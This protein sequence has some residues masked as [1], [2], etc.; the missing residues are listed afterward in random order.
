M[1]DIFRKAIVILI[2]SM[3]LLNSSL[4]LIISSAV[5][6]IEE[7]IDESKVNVLYNINLE[8]YVNYAIEDDK[9]TLVQI[10]LKTGVEFVEGQKYYPI[11]KTDIALNLPKIEGEYPNKVEVIGISTKATNGNEDAKDIKNVYN[12][13]TGEIRIETTNGSNEEGNIYSE[14]VNG[15][16]DEYKLILYYSTQVFSARNIAR[17]LEIKGKIQESF[18]RGKSK[19]VEINEIYNVT[20]NIS[21]LISTDVNTSDIYNGGIK[22]NKENGTSQKTE[23]IENITINPSYRN[24]SD[25]VQINLKNAFI[26]ENNIETEASEI[27]YKSTK[28]NKNEVLEQLGKEGYLQILNE[29]GDI[30][31]EI[32]KDTESG[33]NG[34]VE[35]NYENEISNIIIKTSKIEEL[36]GITIQNVREIKETVKDT[37]IHKI[38]TKGEISCINGGKEVYHFNSSSTTQIK[39]SETRIDVSVD[40]QQLTNNIQNDVV[41]TADLITNKIQYNLFKNPVLEIK[42]PTEVE[43]VILGEVSLLYDENLR[44]SSAEVIDRDNSKVIRMQIEGIQK[45]Y[46]LNS[47]ITGA[48]I[49]IPATIVVKKDIESVDSNIDVTYYNESG[50]NNDYTNR[51]L[52]S[53]IIPISII[54]AFELKE[55]ITTFT[56]NVSTTGD[57][58]ELQLVAYA[59]VGNQVLKD[60]DKVK[61]HEIIRYVMQIKNNSNNDISGLKI[62]AQVP[63]GT[64]YVSIDKSAYLG[65]KYEY[66]EDDTKRTIEED[67]IVIKSGEVI[68]KYYEV[69]A[70]PLGADQLQQ[71]INNNIQLLLNQQQYATL[72]LGNVIEKASIKTELKS[73]IGRVEE[74]TFFYEMYLYNLTDKDINNIYVE[75]SEF[76]KE[77]VYDLNN[78]VYGF[79]Q[80]NGG[81]IDTSLSIT[82]KKYEN[83]KLS[84]NVEK[85]KPNQY[86][87]VYFNVKTED[88]D[89]DIIEQDVKLSYT[90]TVNQNEIYRS[91]ENI[92]SAYPK[93][94]SVSMTSE[95]EGEE[96]QYDEE[97]NYIVKV[98][99][100]GQVGTIVQVTDFLP[101]DLKGIS[102]EYEKYVIKDEN[103]RSSENN[104]KEENIE[105]DTEKVIVDLTN[106]VE[107][108]ANLNYIGF[109]PAGKTMTFN[110]K[111]KA[112]DVDSRTEIANYVTA[113]GEKMDTKVSNTIKSYIIPKEVHT[114]DPDPIDPDPGPIDPDPGPVD[115]DPGPVNPNPGDD[116]STNKYSISGHVWEDKNKDGKRDSS[117]K[118]LS[119]ISVKLFDINVSTMNNENAIQTVITNEKGEY[120][121]SEVPIGKYVVIFEYD[122]NNYKITTYQKVAISEN[123]NSDV[124]NKEIN[125]DGTQK[126]VG[127]TDTLVLQSKNLENIDMGLIK[128]E[129]FDFK[130]DKYV[131]NITVNNSKGT[132]QYTYNDSKLAK[133]EI[134]RKQIENTTINVEYNIIVTN[135]GELDGYVNEILDTK[136]EAL[137]FATNGNEGWKLSSTNNLRNT[138]LTGTKIAPGESKSVKLILTKK[139]TS[140]SAGT[141]KNTVQLASVT[142]LDNREDLDKT[143]NTSDAS[144]IISVK[145]GLAKGISIGMIIIILAVILAYFIKNKKIKRLM[146]VIFGIAIIFSNIS[147]YSN[148]LSDDHSYD[149]IIRRVGDKS[150]EE[151]AALQKYF[152]GTNISEMHFEDTN[153]NV[154]ECMSPGYAQC[155]EGNHYYRGPILMD[156]YPKIFN[157]TEEIIEKDIKFENLNQ[158]EDIGIV[159]EK[160][161]SNY[162]VI[163]PYKMKTNFGG[164]LTIQ[165]KGKTRNGT[166]TQ[167]NATILDSNKRNEI[168]ID[169]I[170]DNSTTTF[171]LK[172]SKNIKVVTNVKAKL[173]VENTSYKMI[174]RLYAYKYE[175]VGVDDTGHSNPKCGDVLS[176]QDMMSYRVEDEKEYMPKT[177]EIEWP[178]D[179]VVTGDLKITKIDYD[180]ENAIPGV[181]FRITGNNV[182]TTVKTDENG[183]AKLEDELMPGTYKVEEI[184]LPDG[185]DLEL[186][187]DTVYENVKIEAG[188]TTKLKIKN[189]K[190]GNLKIIK[191]DKDTQNSN[192]E[193][194]KF[195]GVKFRISYTDEDEKTQYITSYTEGKPS[196]LTV[197]EDK[198]KAYLFETDENAVVE[199]KNIPQSYTYHIEEVDLPKEMTQYYEVSSEVLDVKLENSVGSKETEVKFNNKQQYVDL[200]GYVWEDIASGKL[201]SRNN[202]WNTGDGD[203]AD[204]RIPNIPVYLKKNGTVIAT[205]KTDSNGSYYFPAKGDKEVDDN[206]YDTYDYTINIEE[207]SQYSVEFEYNGLK[208][209]NVLTNQELQKL[210]T[211]SK[212]SETRRDIVNENFSTIYG[213]TA[214]TQN[215]S[216]TGKTST[217]V[218]LTY[219]GIGE[220]GNT[221]DSYNSKLV[222]NTA[223]TKDSLNGSIVDIEAGKMLADTKTAGYEI[224]WS[225]GVKTVKNINLGMYERAQPDMAIVTDMDN[226]RLEINGYNHTYYYK[227]RDEYLEGGIVN[228]AYDA[229]M[230][231]FS[232]LAK[233]SGKYREMTYVREVY[234]SYIAYTKDALENGADHGKLQ[235]FSTYKLVVKNESSNLISQVALRNYADANYF[236]MESAKIVNG[237]GNDQDITE[238]WQKGVTNDGI[239]IWETGII[240]KDIAP[241]ESI[242]ILLQYELDSKVIASM[243]NLEHEQTL[244][245]KRNMTEIIA[246]STFDKDNR[247]KYAGIDKDSAPN[248]IS[249]GNTDTY[250]DDT[251]AAPGFQLKRKPE[252]EA[253]KKISGAVFEDS[254]DGDYK[255]DDLMTNEERK[256]N[257]QY[258]DGENAVENVKVELLTYD[259]DETVK[260]YTLDGVD[261][262]I[263]DAQGMT[264]NEGKY[265]F[266]GLVP[267][268][269]YLKYTYGKFDDKQT[270]IKDATGDINVTTENYKST[271]VDSERFRTLLED[272]N[273]IDASQDKKNKETIANEKLYYWYDYINNLGDSKVSSAVDDVRQ[274]K[275]INDSLSKINYE[276]ETVYQGGNSNSELYYMNSYSGLMDFAIED[277]KNQETQYNE[278]GYINGK[279]DYEVKFGIIERPRQSLQVTKEISKMSL[280]LANGHVIAQGDPRND[281]INYVTYPDGNRLKIEIDSELIQGSNLELEYEMK[282]Y[283]RSELDYNSTEYYRYGNNGG[284]QAIDLSY[285]IADYADENLVFNDYT[286]VNTNVEDYNNTGIDDKTKWQLLGKDGALSENN[287][288]AGIPIWSEVYNNIKTRN[289]ILI[290]NSGISDKVSIRP[291]E[292]S[293]L[294]LVGK[295]LLSSMTDKDTVFNNHIEL[296]QVTNPIGRFYGNTYTAEGVVKRKSIISS[297]TGENAWEATKTGEWKVET[298][299]NYDLTKIGEDSWKDEGDN[300]YYIRAQSTIVPPL[301]E[302]N[303]AIYI[304][305]GIGS[306]LILLGGVILIKKKVLR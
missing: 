174:T 43:K 146:V 18:S 168:S 12:N 16:R 136:P 193:D 73:Y 94:V 162:N 113:S 87:I 178:D 237:N 114:I 108:E 31:G 287:K 253:N 129:K 291:G 183:I 143:N 296:I 271:T 192:L 194:L 214:K 61:E 279:R 221:E 201:S 17:Q 96:L 281:T 247:N 14:E 190:Y 260:L 106:K 142:N 137:S 181:T 48:H 234:D 123:A 273:N 188:R 1:K 185:Y 24:L 23:Y 105:Y 212:A 151:I 262:K 133:V 267:G 251:D 33:E 169:T 299:G 54:S 101:E 208:Y 75:T 79:H 11:E 230:D 27:I 282:V 269:Y 107:N 22:A 245:L 263:E 128:N 239:T 154:Y 6:E 15:V 58:T 160:Y 46:M 122:T 140:S 98:K 34:I 202:L 189:R 177:A 85:I 152:P 261:V 144:V 179:I 182:D 134:D 305:I 38:Q 218:G 229:L 203:T 304:A 88:F 77:I 74:N 268:E 97:I 278:V 103:I 206:N 2:L 44:I 195:K 157:T 104:S 130:I 147:V 68:E 99:N 7:A 220:A 163:G 252:S 78:F 243:A 9:V 37:D 84:F 277:E 120:T 92:R 56:S 26:D 47:M 222:Q 109:I 118:L 165:V 264:N 62:S 135:V 297:L 121:F 89:K 223:Y 240:N 41:F 199:L 159:P 204:I 60:G 72:A 102:A 246:Y 241:G 100:E 191:V 302:K 242:T 63:E 13:K 124:I 250:E 285:V 8:K 236:R 69:I 248:N 70:K 303:I 306:L 259:G 235:L 42:L 280:T 116:S 139:M 167:I 186:Q 216:S 293:T 131:S 76:Q 36:K 164:N 57:D 158:T 39:E 255:R 232:I 138:S 187:T 53:K 225:A 29:N 127:I 283:N 270:V 59:Q 256:G 170:N 112:G 32:N 115:P 197:S 91:N 64:N 5:D 21:G 290:A 180:T 284:M 257:G 155:T 67:N 148:W 289:N 156:G 288:L 20:E 228:S 3:I 161:D 55:K 238:A 10:D 175:C 81:G 215:G 205:R 4:L 210:E 301:G 28:I 213:A 125:I 141:V 71:N 196:K 65:E 172:I 295:K 258:D 219:T 49:I 217:D 110:I 40:K 233:R 292:V 207:A 153:G 298:P 274:R 184:G 35:I 227:Q 173:T 80:N 30:L 66:V 83:N 132:K 226:V 294:R 90:A 111:A 52:N 275:A 176:T 224:K 93:C 126:L 45:N 265:S 231:G 149:V 286:G 82:D 198:D 276:T 95:K 19:A 117:E 166:E 50:L 51:Q 209:E 150:A 300:N 200:E 119:D 266:V 272:I 244:E 249:Y 171:Y 25:E 86:L 211:S 145:T 254:I